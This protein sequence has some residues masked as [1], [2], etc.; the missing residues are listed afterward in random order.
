MNNS[1]EFN[2]SQ[3][4]SSSFDSTEQMINNH[5]KSILEDDFSVRDR[6]RDDELLPLNH[7][8]DKLDDE[9]HSTTV[10]ESKD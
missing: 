8:L 1:G 7:Y 9:D 10:L 4:N 2:F 5:I 6:S 3:S